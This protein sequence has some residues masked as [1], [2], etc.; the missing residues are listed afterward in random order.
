M[1]NLNDNVYTRKN[2][3]K[4]VISVINHT[5]HP[6]LEIKISMLVY[7]IMCWHTIYYLFD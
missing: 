5:L 4:D 1:L 3:I 2:N 7:N 6:E